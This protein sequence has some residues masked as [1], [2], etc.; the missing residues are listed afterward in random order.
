MGYKINPK[1]KT[2]RKRSFDLMISR[3]DDLM[4]LPNIEQWILL[5]S[6]NNNFEMEMSS[7]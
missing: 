1:P 2:P 7:S 3:F 4:S 5:S 6:I